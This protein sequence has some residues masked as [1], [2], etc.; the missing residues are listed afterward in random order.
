MTTLNASVN[1]ANRTVY[2]APVIQ[3]KFQ[4]VKKAISRSPIDALQRELE[5]QLK[6]CPTAQR[7][8]KVTII[9]LPS[10]QNNL[11][12][13]IKTICSGIRRDWHKTQATIEENSEQTYDSTNSYR[14]TFIF[15]RK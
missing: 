4:Q 15:T 6:A 12:R 14:V 1:P 3:R 11:D 10:T 5:A 7:R 8:A 2:T 9:S 13:N